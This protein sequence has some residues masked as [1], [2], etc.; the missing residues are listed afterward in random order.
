MSTQQAV[1]VAGPELRRHAVGLD[2]PGASRVVVT[3]SFCDW[4]P[5]GWPLSQDS[6][7]V[8]E[9][10]LTLPPGRYESRFLVDGE[11]RDDPHCTER[12]AN[13]FGTQNCV[14]EL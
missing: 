12:V 6:G 13:P 1:G 4:D 14:L 2:A 5:T 11:W 9:A 3:G 7:G 8:W 10:L